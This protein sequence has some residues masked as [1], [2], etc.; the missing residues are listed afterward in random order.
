MMK[1]FDIIYNLIKHNDKKGVAIVLSYMINTKSFA[2]LQNINYDE[3]VNIPENTRNDVTWYVWR[4]LLCIVDHKYKD[5]A[6]VKETIS[7]VFELFLAMYQKKNRLDRMNLMIYA[8]ILLCD[9][10]FKVADKSIDKKVIAEAVNKVEIVYCDVL[11]KDDYSESSATEFSGSLA[12]LDPSIIVNVNNR[13]KV[14]VAPPVVVE[15]PPPPEAK[16]QD[17]KDKMNYLNKMIYFEE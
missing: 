7:L 15:Q 8:F 16:K 4:L 11:N 14:V 2:G 13:E 1:L 3:I 12:Y 10:T 17:D 6:L 5:S 9:D